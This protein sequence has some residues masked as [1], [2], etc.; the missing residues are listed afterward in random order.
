MTQTKYSHLGTGP[1]Q[2]QAREMLTGSPEKPVGQCICCASTKVARTDFRDELSWKEYH[3]SCLCQV[4][5]D[6]VFG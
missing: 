4:C 2:K 3:I 6:S 1:A 5:Q